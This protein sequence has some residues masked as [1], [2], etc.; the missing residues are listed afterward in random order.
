MYKLKDLKVNLLG[1]FNRS[2]LHFYSLGM[3]V[4]LLFTQT[5]FKGIAKKEHIAGACI[6]LINCMFNMLKYKFYFIVHLTSEV[7]KAIVKAEW[8]GQL[9]SIQLCEK[10]DFKLKLSRIFIALAS[11]KDYAKYIC[12][13]QSENIYFVQCMTTKMEI[14][15]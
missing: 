7:V 14:D 3:K 15:V 6:Y 12:R 10:R 2:L 8:D 4:L 9:N 5:K 13:L 11:Y 1:L